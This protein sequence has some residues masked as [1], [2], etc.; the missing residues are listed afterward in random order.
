MDF[1][2][3]GKRLGGRT[4][5]QWSK[6]ISFALQSWYSTPWERQQ[7]DYR[8]TQQKIYERK[9]VKNSEYWPFHT[10]IKER[11][12]LEIREYSSPQRSPALGESCWE[13]CITSTNSQDFLLVSSSLLL[14]P[15]TPEMPI[16]N[17]IGG[18]YYANWGFDLDFFSHS[19]IL[20]RFYFPVFA[21]SWFWFC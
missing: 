19:C 13:N 3:K 20:P 16:L 14:A 10:E 11:C 5:T 1:S 4:E 12:I 7:S 15:A 6:A 9:I 17:E 2:Y 18:F 8:T 21:T